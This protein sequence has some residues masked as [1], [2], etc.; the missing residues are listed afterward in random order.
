MDMLLVWWMVHDGWSEQLQ[1]WPVA[2]GGVEEGHASFGAGEGERQ[3]RLWRGLKFG[4]FGR[5]GV[6]M[7]NW[8]G[9]GGEVSV[10]K[11]IRVS[12]SQGMW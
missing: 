3:R 5:F 7:G 4:L 1:V 10:S 2:L 8:N 9:L 11:G 12:P 6:E